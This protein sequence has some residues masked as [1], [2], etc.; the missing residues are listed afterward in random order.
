MSIT[1]SSVLFLVAIG[2]FVAM[3][4]FAR[5]ISLH[6]IDDF[7]GGDAQ[8]WQGA[9]GGVLTDVGPEGIGDH[10]LLVSTTGFPAGVNSRLLAYHGGSST[11]IATHW[12]GD[13]SAAGVRQIAIDALNPNPFTL[14]IWLGIA[15]PAGPGGSGSNDAHVTRVSVTLPPDEEWHPVEF[16]VLADDFVTWGATGSPTAALADVYQFRILHSPAQE[17]R[18]ALGEASMLLDNIR[19]I[20]EPGSTALLCALFVVPWR[21]RRMRRALR[22]F[23]PVSIHS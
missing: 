10:S 18:G 5:A 22:S 8:G 23:R 2:S 20:P 21:A 19:P 6:Q 9:V 13:W 14:T 17:W 15:G 3:T 1:K 4:S 11:P 12:T 7:Q 16:R